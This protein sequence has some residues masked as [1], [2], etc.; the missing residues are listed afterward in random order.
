MDGSALA[1]G[2]VTFPIRGC[3]PQVA[4]ENGRAHIFAVGDIVEPVEEW[5]AYKKEQTGREWDYVFRRLFYARNMEVEHGAF[6]EPIEVANVDATA[7]H[8]SNQDM[9]VA[10]NGDAYLMYLESEVGS[11]LMRDKYFSGKSTIPS[12]VLAK[13]RDGAIAERHVLVS[14]AEHEHAGH[15]RFHVT[16]KGEVYALVYVAGE[17]A[18]NVLIPV[19]PNLAPDQ[20]V[21]VPF[22]SP[23]GS[24]L[25]ASAR[26]GNAASDTIDLIGTNGKG[27]TMAY[28]QVVI[29]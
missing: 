7:G 16:P 9:W 8:L 20:R 19:Y 29:E 6:G 13:V 10:P 2:S 26:A 15:A 17:T 23:F 24:F 21:P 3:Y 11:A 28:G 4:I 14:N 5:R 27:N 25:L 12:L 18:R 1:N 22:K